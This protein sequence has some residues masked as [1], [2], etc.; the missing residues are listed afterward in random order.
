[1]CMVVCRNC[2]KWLIAFPCAYHFEPKEF[3]KRH[4]RLYKKYKQ[5]EQEARDKH[6]CKPKDVIKYQ[7]I[8]KRI[9][10]EHNL[11]ANRS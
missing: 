7:A 11:R 3:E 1:M 6:K 2:G 4:P 8:I 9:E 10:D 5:Q